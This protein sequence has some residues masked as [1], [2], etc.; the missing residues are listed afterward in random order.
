MHWIRDRFDPS[1]WEDMTRNMSGAL[2]A[3][4][5]VVALF[6]LQG[7]DDELL[8]DICVCGVWLP[9]GGVPD[10]GEPDGGDEQ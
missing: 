2:S 10:G 6:L 1:R 5:V 3:A 4:A 8:G 7:C 9:D